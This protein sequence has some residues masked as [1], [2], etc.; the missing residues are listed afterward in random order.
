MHFI[1]NALNSFYSL[2]WF[3]SKSNR[4]QYQRERVLPMKNRFQ[5]TAENILDHARWAPSGDNMQTWR[6]EIVDTHCFIV[7]GYDTRDHCVYDLEGHASQ[8][9]IGAL[10]ESIAIAA[11]A[12]K[13]RAEFQL[14]ENALE[15][16]PT[17]NVQLIEDKNIEQDPL[18][19]YL[20]KRSVQ[21]RMLKTTPLSL[22]DKSKLEQSVGNFYNIKWIEGWRAR[23][24]AAFLMYKNGRLRLILPE[25]FPTH[26]TIIEWNSRFSD[27]K[28]PDQAVGLDMVAMRMMRWAMKS[29]KRVSFLN[30]FLAGTLLPR[31]ELDLLPGI[32][33]AAHFS[34]VAEKEPRT[35]EDYLNAGRAVQRFW[36]T[37]TMLGLQ[38]QPEM[39]PL[40]FS[41]YIKNKV[42]FTKTQKIHDY[43]V[44]LS[45]VFKRLMG[46]EAVIDKAVF[47]GRIGYGKPAKARSL[48]LSLEQLEY[49]R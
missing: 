5:T 38:L 46:G 34:L 18:F 30:T 9:A 36:L 16:K 32:A 8:L 22:K 45:K 47:V 24:Q 3:W 26:S 40:I 7:H 28:I 31:I 15:T 48:R 12:F 19:L 14:D 20:P 11:S 43:A 42:E 4:F 33:C 1:S 6:F 23:L 25:A 13:C 17:I 27:D 35:M 2:I 10:L 39:T 44:D 37:S 41:G 29:W 21:R 49:K